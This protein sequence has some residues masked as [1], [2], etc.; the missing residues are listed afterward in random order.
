MPRF[1]HGAMATC[2][3]NPL[4]CIIYIRMVLC[5][6]SS[7]PVLLAPYTPNILSITM[8]HISPSDPFYIT[9]PQRLELL[10][11]HLSGNNAFVNSVLPRDDR[12]AYQVAYAVIGRI[13]DHA[14]GEARLVLALRPGHAHRNA[15]SQADRPEFIHLIVAHCAQNYREGLYFEHY[16]DDDM[17]KTLKDAFSDIAKLQ[18]LYEVFYAG[19]WDQGDLL[20][21]PPLDPRT[22]R[23]QVQASIQSLY[24]PQMAPPKLTSL[25]YN[26][27]TLGITCMSEIP[28]RFIE[29]SIRRARDRIDNGLDM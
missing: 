8:S 4:S 9:L 17:P 29:E 27:Q 16:I 14:G 6:S 21:V 18:I 10:N 20:V 23:R 3:G 2:A 19:L 26:P 13:P 5:G 28:L 15:P 24:G 1:V 12:D 22:I 11:A 7:I 25:H